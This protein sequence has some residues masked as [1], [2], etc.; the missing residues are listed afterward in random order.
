[1]VIDNASP[2]ADIEGKI[3]QA[4][5]ERPGLR[6]LTLS[7]P[8]PPTAAYNRGLAAARGDIVAFLDDDNLYAP[9]GLSRLAAALASGRHDIVVSALDMFDEDAKRAMPASDA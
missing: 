5:N 1:M 7:E 3:R 6:V 2:I 9:D 8:L 4:A